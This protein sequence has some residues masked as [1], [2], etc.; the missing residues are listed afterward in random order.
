MF[1]KSKLFRT[2]CSVNRFEIKD[3]AFGKYF[4]Y[5]NMGSY[6]QRADDGGKHNKTA[7]NVF[8]LKN[9]RRIQTCWNIFMTHSY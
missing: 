4:C 7:G 8:E 9:E 2:V 3:F 5:Q 1:Q 6:T